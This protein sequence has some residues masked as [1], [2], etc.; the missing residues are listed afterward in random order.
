MYPQ[1]LCPYNVPHFV[2]LVGTFGDSSETAHLD[3]F[4]SVEHN[5]LP[6]KELEVAYA[7]ESNQ[8]FDVSTPMLYINYG[9]KRDR[10][11]SFVDTL[12]LSVR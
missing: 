11:G 6:V 4:G 7:G 2:G 9:R 5:T 10:T 12:C 3:S 1:R 8:I